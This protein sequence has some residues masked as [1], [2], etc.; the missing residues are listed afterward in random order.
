MTWLMMARSDQ[1]PD[2]KSL[3]VGAET[4]AVMLGVSIKTVSNWY[5][6]GILPQAVRLPGPRRWRRRD[7]EEWIAAG[8]SKR[9]WKRRNC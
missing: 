5:L 4:V 7:I 1:A 2:G 3:L 6:A 8:C 9:V